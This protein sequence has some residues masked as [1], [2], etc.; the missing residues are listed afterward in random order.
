MFEGRRQ[1]LL[2]FRRF[3]IRMGGFALAALIVDGFAWGVGTIGYHVLEDLDWLDACLNAA[4]VMTGNGPVNPPRTP[5]GKL[6]TI[7]D[8]LVGSIL[9]AGVIG[10]LLIPV[11]HRMLH[12]FHIK[13]GPDEDKDEESVA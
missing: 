5:G 2:S 3:A 6:F 7:L 10:A 9:F 12:A 4:L 11:F 1:P 8:A 13:H